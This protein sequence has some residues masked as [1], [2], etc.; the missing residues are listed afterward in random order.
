M[1]Y[2]TLYKK[3]EKIIVEHVSIAYKLR[4]RGKW[5]PLFFICIDFDA[6]KNTIFRGNYI[7]LYT[8]F[9][10]IY[11]YMRLYECIKFCT[12]SGNLFDD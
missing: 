6:F 1:G 9:L 8:I 3:Q 11:I 7:Q 2:T 4:K 12:F 10:Q 5:L